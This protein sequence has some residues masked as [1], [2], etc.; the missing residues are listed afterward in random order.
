MPDNYDNVCGLCGKLVDEG[1]LYYCCPECH[2]VHKKKQDSLDNSQ[3]TVMKE[4]EI[5]KEEIKDG[6]LC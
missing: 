6:K 4:G 3:Q 5:Q 1:M 2:R